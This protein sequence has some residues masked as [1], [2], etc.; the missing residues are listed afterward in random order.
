MLLY[1][2][3]SNTGDR[4]INED[5]HISLQRGGD[6]CFVVAD[7]L[8]GHG[9]GEIASQ[10]LVGA[11]RRIFNGADAGTDA[12]TNPRRRLFFR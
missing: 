6:Y 11:F 10:M 12:V 2:T 7:G 9:K 3:I 5:S 4:E 1:N 8:G